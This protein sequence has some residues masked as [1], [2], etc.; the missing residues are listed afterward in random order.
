M[1]DVTGGEGVSRTLGRCSQSQTEGPLANA[2]RGCETSD[3]RVQEGTEEGTGGTMDGGV[4]HLNA[5][6]EL[7]SEDTFLI[8][9]SL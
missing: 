3:R 6:T 5:L 4:R 8:D 7:A 9:V 2:H 1:R